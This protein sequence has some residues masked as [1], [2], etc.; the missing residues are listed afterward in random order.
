MNDEVST[1]QGS[2]IVGGDSSINAM[3]GDGE[4]L[5]IHQDK[6]HT[7][8]SV[9]PAL[10]TKLLLLVSL[11]SG[12]FLIPVFHH[13]FNHVTDAFSWLQYVHVIVWAITL[14]L[15]WYIKAEHKSSR[16]LGYH[17]FY[18][19]TRHLHRITFY[20]LS[21]GNVLLI[22][23]GNLV[24]D[25]CLEDPL[26][27]CSVNLDLSPVN[28][29]QIIFLLEICTAVPFVIKHIVLV[30]RFNAAGLIPDVLAE[31]M[32]LRFNTSDSY[33]GV[34]GPSS[35]EWVL[36]RQADLLQVLRHRNSILTQQ[37][38]ALTQ[39]IQQQA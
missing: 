6:E 10:Y 31:D 25:Y 12:G 38:Y 27:S 28:Y 33:V 22:I 14:V 26:S 36:E 34:R 13:V 4:P 21:G 23:L 29:Q 30:A 39:Q 2:V 32:A 19:S 15:T 35:C 1:V 3:A 9:I 17:E 11:V 24:N 7:P 20:V 37:L 8:L 16:I 18:N 5:V